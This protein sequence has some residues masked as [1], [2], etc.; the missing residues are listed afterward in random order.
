MERVIG[1]IEKCACFVWWITVVVP[2]APLF[3]AC[4]L[5]RLSG[6]HDWTLHSGAEDFF[7]TWR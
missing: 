6:G 5:G 1:G 4:D 7:A 3:V 2:E